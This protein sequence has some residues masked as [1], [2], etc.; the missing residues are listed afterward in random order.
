[1][2]S[3]YGIVKKSAIRPACNALGKHEIF[4]ARW[5]DLAHSNTE[6]SAASKY[7]RSD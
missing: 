7:S 2:R 5:R 4:S 1:M 3:A 6:R